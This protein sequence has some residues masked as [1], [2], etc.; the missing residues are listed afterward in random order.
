LPVGEI[1]H[2]LGAAAR[3][4]LAAQL[5]SRPTLP[6][7]TPVA[8]DPP[9]ADIGKYEVLLRES[10]RLFNAVGYRETSMEDIAAAS[11]IPASSIYRYFTGKGDILAAAYRRA[12]DRVSGDLSD[13]LRS[14]SNPEDALC[15]L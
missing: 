11:G 3:S 6:C 1:R 2:V 4:A 10:L 9:L 15:E 13:V 7:V 5:P 12:A 8:I 14:T